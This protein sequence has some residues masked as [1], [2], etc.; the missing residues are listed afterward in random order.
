MPRPFV[1]ILI[2]TY[3]HE[4][5]IGEAVRSVLEQD[6]PGSDR[7]IL[8]V[9]DGS[10]DG[11]PDILEAFQPH[12][13]ILRKANGGQ[14]SAFNFGI[15]ECRG[16][17]IAFLDG[18]DWWLPGKLRR[19]AEIFSKEPLVGVLGHG[20]LQVS[21]GGCHK[22]APA[23]EL[24]FRLDSALS[25]ELFRLHRC[26][27]GTSR[28]ALRA[29]LARKILPV[30]KSLSFEADEYLFTLAP[31]LGD[32]VILQELLTCYRMHGANLFLASGG[33][34]EG[35]RRKQLVLT[36]LAAELRA[37]LSRW[38]VAPDVTR[39]V[40]EMVELEATQL[41][42]QFDGGSPWETFRTETTIYRIQ[43]KGVSRRSRV[44]RALSMVPALLLPPRWFYAGRRWL[45]SQ[46]WYL[47]T[48]KSILP[49][50][51]FIP[52]RTDRHRPAKLGDDI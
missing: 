43:H 4:R 25:A 17:V 39:I 24:R 9:D 12:I 5:F 40:V 33:T 10:W 42:L 14:A 44:F 15:P 38:G 3:N 13:R 34:R 46:A 30:P 19:V 16:E 21:E 41:R 31:V 51:A 22:V 47:R 52:E 48:R 7:E 28:L 1:S 45:A 23:S 32:T 11:T 27:L 35:E 6:F 18:D 26:Y 29:E 2:D 8:V 49:S 36:A 20:I 37:V 50:P